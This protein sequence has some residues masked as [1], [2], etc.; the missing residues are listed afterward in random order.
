MSS[1][2]VLFP[3]FSDG[4]REPDPEF[5]KE[6]QALDALSIPW[7]VVNIDALIAGD[8]AKTFQ[9]FSP[10]AG[11][12][13]YRGWILHTHEYESLHSELA[14]RGCHLITN[15]AAYRQG[16]L[17][18]EFYPAIRTH[19]FPA[20]W[21]AGCNARKAWKIAES[22][23]PPPYFIKD[24]SKSAKEIW[25]E[26]CVVSGEDGMEGMSRAIRA[27]RKYRGDRFESGIVIRP[28][29]RLKYIGESAFGRAIHEEY[30]L[31]FFR[32]S[33][34]VCSW[35]DRAGG[36]LT[37]LPDYS[38]LFERIASP[39]FSADIVRTEDG[40][41]YIIEIGDGGVSGLPPTVSPLQFYRNLSNRLAL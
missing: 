32:G 20:A 19:S 1:F 9:F 23:G 34:V 38:F 18:P 2:T 33:L 14:S 29:M 28:L 36:D 35:Y 15:P 3:S 4:R 37:T 30:R 17:F 7:R 11:K 26:G 24:Y 12:L 40:A 6:A 25:P 41:L 10:S 13:L 27:L 21:I 39:F 16:L 31:F 5:Y 8:L 22:L